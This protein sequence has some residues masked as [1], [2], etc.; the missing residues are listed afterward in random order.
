[1][2]VLR[3][4]AASF[5]EW[6]ECV[7]DLGDGNQVRLQEDLDADDNPI[8][9]LWATAVYDTL[10][11]PLKLAGLALKI[12]Q[13]QYTVNANVELTAAQARTLAAALLHATRP[14]DTR[15]PPDA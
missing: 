9:V 2:A 14:V 13:Q 3:V 12:A 6:G 10:G 5:N 1:M 7:L 15:E 11:E 8:V 4:P